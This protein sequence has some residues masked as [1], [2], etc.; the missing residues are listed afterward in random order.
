MK[1]THSFRQRDSS[2]CA[3]LLLDICLWSS[4]CCRVYVA[5]EITLKAHSAM[6]WDVT[7]VDNRQQPSST[8]NSSIAPRRHSAKQSLVYICIV[9]SRARGASCNLQYMQLARIT[10]QQHNANPSGAKF[11][12]GK[13]PSRRDCW[14][15][16]CLTALMGTGG[17]S[18]R[19]RLWGV[20][21]TVKS[22]S[23][24]LMFIHRLVGSG[25]SEL[26]E[27]FLHIPKLKVYGSTAKR[28]RRT[29]N[30]RL[31]GSSSDPHVHKIYP[32]DLQP[33]SETHCV[34]P[35]YHCPI[36]LKSFSLH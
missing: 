21:L 18:S 36:I 20:A 3:L 24:L 23:P 35:W 27:R 29:A 10:L 5:V 12:C 17:G 14:L 16:C 6:C 13:A 4:L 34:I 33:F 30:S 31:T 11:P 28:K 8:D 25:R 26:Q 2:W 7:R 32:L 1:N 9:S 19:G 22:A 15:S